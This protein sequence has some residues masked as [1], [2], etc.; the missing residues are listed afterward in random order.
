[1]EDTIEVCSKCGKMPRALDQE[2]GYFVCTRCGNNQLMAVK[3]D[4]YERIVTELDA[5]YQ[6]RVAQARLEVVE[7]EMPIENPKKKTSR[8]TATKK[9]TSK[10]APA[11]K[12]AAK[13]TTKKKKK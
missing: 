11:K 13:K 2:S 10:K 4:D 1:M 5:N 12:K 6:E 9:K 3:S 7:K 8:K